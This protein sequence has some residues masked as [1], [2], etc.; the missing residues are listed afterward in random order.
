MLG[1]LI[2]QPHA[3]RSSSV[4]SG[5]SSSRCGCPTSVLPSPRQSR[6]PARRRPD[7]SRGTCRRTAGRPCSGP[8][9]PRRSARTLGAVETRAPVDDAVEL[10]VV[11]Q[12]LHHAAPADRRGV[13]QEAV[14]EQR[15]LAWVLER[16]EALPQHP[17]LVI[18]AWIAGLEPFEVAL[19][20]TVE[21]PVG[22]RPDRERED[23]G[24]VDQPVAIRSRAPMN[25][26]ASISSPSLPSCS[27]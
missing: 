16:V 6:C 3:S 20:E 13:L 12:A 27:M 25:G 21:A 1:L 11:T 18:P 19:V 2:S 23:R 17:V 8:G 7:P 22:E 4:H 24:A 15:A 9:S 14:E 26:P 10:V 5:V